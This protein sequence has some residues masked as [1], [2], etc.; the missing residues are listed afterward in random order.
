MA[1][2]ADGAAGTADSQ[3]I[4][5]QFVSARKEGRALPVF[6]GALPNTLAEAYAIQDAAI[7]L[8]GEAIAGWK[9]GRIPP[10]HEAVL[11]EQRLAGPIFRSVVQIAGA[12]PST[13]AVIEGGFAAIEA[14]FVF[15]LGKDADPARTDWTGDDAA[16]LVAALHVGVEVAA[17]PLAAIN[18]IGPR[19]VVSD[20]GNNGGLILGPEISDWRTRDPQS[21]PCQSFI[22]DVSVGT[23]SAG[24]LLD[25]PLGSLVFIL[26]HTARR[27]M[28]LKAGQL[29]AT[30]QTSGIHDI[31]IGQFGRIVFGSFGA[32]EVRA[33]KQKAG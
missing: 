28:P 29:I 33:T 30:G 31:E 5:R 13:F 4:A 9:V 17:S 21:L 18:I 7:S 22:E 10:E 2:G 3:A 19:A 1:A 6:P 27:G 23:G 11:H 14:E 12:G 32:I 8:R 24:A 26:A 15:R 16:E 25:G 20:F